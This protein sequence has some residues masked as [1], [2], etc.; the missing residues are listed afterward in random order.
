MVGSQR[1][2]PRMMKSVHAI[3][4]T[5]LSVALVA[6]QPSGVAAAEAGNAVGLHDTA[7]GE[8]A[9][10]HLRALQDIA[11]A[12]GGN[13]AAGTAGYDRSAE[14]VAEKLREAGYAVRFEAFDFPFFEERTPPV[15]IVNASDGQQAPAAAAAFRTLNNSGTADVTARLRAVHLDLDG[16]PPRASTSGCEAGDLAG[17]ERGAVALVR[18]GTCTFQTK[19][20]NAVAAG[21]VG[22]IIM[23]E[24]TQGRAA[25]FSGQLS[26]PAAVPIVGVSYEF[27]RSLENAAR[28]GAA[29]RLAVDAVSGMRTTRNV[30]ADAAGDGSGALT[31]VGAHLDS[32]PAGPGINDNGSGSAAV[33][34]T[35]LQLPPQARRGLRFAFWGAEEIGLVGSRHHVGALSEDE[36][37]R[38]A[39]Y[40]NLDMVGSPNFVRLV[41]RS[42]ASSALADVARHELLADF[43]EHNL[44]VSERGGGSYGTDDASFFEKGIATVGLYTG[45]DR[46]KSEADARL[47]GGTAGRPNDPCYHQACDTVD[48]INRGVLEENAR[49]LMRAVT[50]VAAATRKASSEPAAPAAPAAPAQA[51]P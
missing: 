25:A 40:I 43:N 20:E 44:P 41:Q 29:V 24:G 33:L 48:N 2:S 19:V 21:A 17:F 36:R 6:M 23:N 12:N 9:F 39:L 15:L 27:G 1:C 16:G 13:R 28:G 49:A 18:R 31:V 32:V 47:F 10:R 14:Y 51:N 7:P 45:A 37:R 4:M 11:S 8:G 42:S 26:R 46:P 22:V 35:A 3:L 30:L 34:E 5:S 38:V 50:A